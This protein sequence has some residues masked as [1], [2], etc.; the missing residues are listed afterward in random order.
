LLPYMCILNQISSKFIYLS[1][2][3]YV[4]PLY[5][6]FMSF[7]CP[8]Y[9]LFMSFLCPVYVLFM[10]CLC[11]FYVLFMSFV[12]KYGYIKATICLFFIPPIIPC[13]PLIKHP[14][15]VPH[16]SLICPSFV[17]HLSLICP[18]FVALLT[19]WNECRLKDINRT[20][21]LFY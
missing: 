5:V 17:P 15:F 7:L 11:P 6:L 12:D 19:V 14:S 1:T 21:C 9:V 10:S 13:L 16:L 2:M 4:C 3:Y 18:S 20:F 8:F